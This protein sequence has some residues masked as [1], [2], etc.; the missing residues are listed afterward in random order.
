MYF[1]DTLRVQMYENDDLKHGAK[2][3][4]W[5]MSLATKKRLLSHPDLNLDTN[6]EKLF[7][8][9]SAAIKNNKTKFLRNIL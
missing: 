2:D 7:A 8:I 3:V 6:G 1:A 4:L 5:P 9:S